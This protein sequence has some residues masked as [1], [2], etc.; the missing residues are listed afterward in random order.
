M[1]NVEDIPDHQSGVAPVPF[2]LD[3]ELEQLEELDDMPDLEEELP[4]GAVVE[5]EQS[6]ASLAPDISD[7]SEELPPELPPEIPPDVP[8][9][10]RRSSRQVTKRKTITEE[11]NSNSLYFQQSW[12]N[13]SRKAC[14]NKCVR[15]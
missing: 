5:R 15:I 9:R 3:E 13:Y 1:E 11:L 4:L 7:A 2:E 6:R 10:L 14:V 8:P 12:L